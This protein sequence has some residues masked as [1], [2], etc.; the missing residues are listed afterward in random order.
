MYFV[1]LISVFFVLLRLARLNLAFS[2]HSRQHLVS[3]GLWRVIFHLFRL[4]SNRS[5]NSVL[6]I[7]R[8]LLG[9]VFSLGFMSLSIPFVV[10]SV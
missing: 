9:R 8:V 3:K 1:R 7:S 6:W 4:D 10:V 2:Q 5:A